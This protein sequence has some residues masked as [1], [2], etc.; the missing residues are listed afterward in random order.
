MS[1]T[2]AVSTDSE[3]SIADPNDPGVLDVVVFDTPTPQL[4]SDFARGAL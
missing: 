1:I 3:T 4:I 2:C